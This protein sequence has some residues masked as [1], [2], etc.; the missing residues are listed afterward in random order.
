METVQNKRRAEDHSEER[1][2]NKKSRT[3]PRSTR[4]GASSERRNSQESGWNMSSDETKKLFDDL[5]AHF[6]ITSQTTTEKFER[7]VQSVDARVTDNAAAI[8]DLRESV[9]RMES[10]M[11][12]TV[13]PT[14]GPPD[15]QHKD[16]PDYRRERYEAARKML[17]LWPVRGKEEDELRQETIRFIRQKL[18]VCNISCT[19]AQIMKVRRTKQP[20]K[21]SVNNEV[22]VIFQDKYSRDQVVANAKHLSQYRLQ[23]G[24][25]TAGLRMNY[26]DHLS[27][28]FRSLDWVWGRAKQAS[29]RNKKKYKIRR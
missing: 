8:T 17:R 1:G 24:K 11:K 13:T 25:P 20:R 29:P 9:R 19:D 7:I 21:S 27:S 4:R 22:L 3:T 5:K 2:D 15:T 12:A 18:Q 16:S 10:N 26:P 6:D 23:D 28:D 14:T